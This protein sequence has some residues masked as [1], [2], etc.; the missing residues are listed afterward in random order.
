MSMSHHTPCDEDGFVCPYNAQNAADCEYWC[1]ANQ[2][3]DI[4]DIY[5]NYDTVYVEQRR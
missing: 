2:E 1:G 5:F 3:P 4:D